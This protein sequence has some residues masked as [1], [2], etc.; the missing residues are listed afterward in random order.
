MLS[1]LASYGYSTDSF[2]DLMDLA[3]SY[4]NAAFRRI[5]SVPRSILK[6]DVFSCPSGH[7]AGLAE[8]ERKICIGEDITS[9]LSRGLKKLDGEDDLLSDWGVYHLHLGTAIES[10]GF[11]S[12]TGPVLYAIPSESKMHF[13]QAYS[14]GNW[15]NRDVIE[16]VH[17]NWPQI[18]APFSP[19]GVVDIS[20]N[21]DSGH[22]AKFRK[23][24][25]NT[26]LKMSDGTIYFS[27]GLGMM[28]DGTSARAV[29]AAQKGIRDVAQ[30]DAFISSQSSTVLDA[31]R[32][33]GHDGTTEVRFTLSLESTG[34]YAIAE[35][36]ALRLKLA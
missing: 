18:L 28:T 6:S 10:D 19:K 23:A 27:P 32:E 16:I 22:I 1:V 3:V 5:P 7:E 34:V 33:A 30:W 14:H 26:S 36:W 11:M 13:I 21:P 8:L 20:M 4:Y 17:R 25:I 35:T 12:R 9:H 31:L 29:L 2:S 24:H 15:S